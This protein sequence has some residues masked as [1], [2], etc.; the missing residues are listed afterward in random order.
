[1]DG[2]GGIIQNIKYDGQNFNTEVNYQNQMLGK[3]NTDIDKTHD[4]M[5]KVDSKLKELIAKSS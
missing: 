5:V 1:M 4:K 2:L 3:L